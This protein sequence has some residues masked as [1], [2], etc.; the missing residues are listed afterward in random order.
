[1]RPTS[2]LR[3][4]TSDSPD[5][6]AI[7][8]QEVEGA[9]GLAVE[10][11]IQEIDGPDLVVELRLLESSAVVP[12]LVARAVERSTD[13]LDVLSTWNEGGWFA[14]PA[15]VPVPSQLIL[16]GLD[17]HLPPV[18]RR[19]LRDDLPTA[20]WSSVGTPD[21]GTNAPGSWR[22]PSFDATAGH[23]S[24]T[25]AGAATRSGSVLTTWPWPAPTWPPECEPTGGPGGA[26]RLRCRL[27]CRRRYRLRFGRGGRRCRR[28]PCVAPR[29]SAPPSCRPLCRAAWGRGRWDGGS[30]SR[31]GRCPHRPSR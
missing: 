17:A 28:A 11:E 13:G 16:D 2:K 12:G 14:D 23:W 1:M 31:T 20:Q 15:P 26:Q 24:A 9:T 27:T 8:R 6:L 18:V 7:I 25:N 30:P 10:P 22:C 3:V 4:V 29:V 21:M 19:A 5:A